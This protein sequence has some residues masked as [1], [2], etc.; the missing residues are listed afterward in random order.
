MSEHPHIA[1]CCLINVFN[2]KMRSLS[3]RHAF[4]LNNIYPLSRVLRWRW[5]RPILFFIGGTSKIISRPTAW[6]GSEQK[7]LRTSFRSSKR[8]HL[9]RRLKNYWRKGTLVE[10]DW[11]PFKRRWKKRCCLSK[12]IIDATQVQVSSTLGTSPHLPLSSLPQTRSQ[13]TG[14]FSNRGC[15]IILTCFH[16]LEP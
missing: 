13:R 5:K 8:S 3:R 1:G 15:R 4:L 9:Q 10:S 6:K 2:T 14:P 7:S 12:K 11:Y 16:V